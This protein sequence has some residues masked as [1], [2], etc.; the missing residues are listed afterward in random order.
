[1]F[2]ITR[3]YEID[4]YLKS[5]LVPGC[6]L[7]IDP[8]QSQ[9]VAQKYEVCNTISSGAI[10]HHL[11]ILSTPFILSFVLEVKDNYGLHPTFSSEDFPV[12]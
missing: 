6:A 8:P 3:S 9:E 7:A 11:F 5:T 4:D 12:L 1:M 10:R 2:I